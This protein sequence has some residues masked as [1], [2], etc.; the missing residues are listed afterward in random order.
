MPKTKGFIPAFAIAKY[1]AKCPNAL[2][3]I[4][5]P[6]IA[7]SICFALASDCESSFLYLVPSLR[8]LLN[9]RFSKWR[10]DHVKL[11]SGSIFKRPKCCPNSRIYVQAAINLDAAYIHKTVCG[12]EDLAARLCCGSLFNFAAQSVAGR[13]AASSGHA[14]RAAELTMTF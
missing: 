8:V 1:T 3:N 14:D 10:L 11:R 5:A 7:N 2:I 13:C 6:A 4:K 12:T 9:Q